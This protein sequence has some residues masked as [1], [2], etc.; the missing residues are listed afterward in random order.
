MVLKTW[1]LAEIIS[2]TFKVNKCKLEFSKA[3]KTFKAKSIKDI[4]VF[5]LSQ[6]IE[7]RT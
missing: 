2:A 3:R 6:A 5:I 1:H 4:A 7:S